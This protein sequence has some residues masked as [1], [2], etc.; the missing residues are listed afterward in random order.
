MQARRSVEKLLARGF[1]TIASVPQDKQDGVWKTVIA[2]P[3]AQEEFT[4][5]R[6]QTIPVAFAAW[7]GARGE[8]GGIHA[9]PGKGPP[10]LLQEAEV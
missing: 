5:A 4:F 6:G 3:R 9:A 10:P 7:D 2:I 1:G 8:R